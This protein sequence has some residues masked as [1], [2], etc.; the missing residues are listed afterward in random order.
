MKAWL[1]RSPTLDDLIQ[2]LQ[3]W[4]IWLLA[5]LAGALLGSAVHYFVPP[6]YRAQAAVTVDHNLEQ[7]WPDAETERS[8]MTYLSRETQKLIQVAWNDATLQLVVDQNPGTSLTGLRAGVLQLSQPSDGVW[9]FW[10][11]DADASQAARLASTWAGAFYERSLHGVDIA[12]QLQ[13]AQA[14][15]L[16]MPAEAAALTEQIRVLEQESLGISPYLQLNFSQAEHLP[17]SRTYSSL[18]TILGGA[19]LAWVV[20]LLGFLF[21]GSHKAQ[22]DNR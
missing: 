7:A 19:V 15:L 22:S 17:V 11:D 4:R 5:T 21:A 18:T 9:H 12:I 6:D 8:L 16:Q 1:L 13:V 20:T 2:V 14:A 10:A 3:A